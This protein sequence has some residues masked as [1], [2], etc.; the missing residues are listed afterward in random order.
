[1]GKSTGEINSN[2]FGNM[3]HPNI[4]TR[5]FKA[6]IFLLSNIIIIFFSI[7]LKLL[8]SVQKNTVVVLVE[9]HFGP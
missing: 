7:F 8:P 2:T 6:T 1:M 3:T 4:Q 9:M 5:K